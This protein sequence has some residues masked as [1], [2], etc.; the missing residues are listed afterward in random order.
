MDQKPHDTEGGRS[1]DDL[2]ALRATESERTDDPHI[3]FSET[4]GLL[5]ASVSKG[6]PRR[7]CS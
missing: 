4:R 3:Y 1:H 2:A 5:R 6:G 7:D